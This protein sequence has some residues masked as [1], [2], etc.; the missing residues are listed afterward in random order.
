MTYYFLLYCN[1]IDLKYLIYINLILIP[2]TVV[3][4][5]SDKRDNYAEANKKEYI[6]FKC[7]TPKNMC[8]Q[9]RLENIKK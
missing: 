1:N 4:T 6:N 8:A 9:Q 7:V 2:E 5:K 3:S